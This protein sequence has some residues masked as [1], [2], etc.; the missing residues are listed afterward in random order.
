MH[1]ESEKS[2]LTS[3]WRISGLRGKGKVQ[4]ANGR[5]GEL[6]LV[7]HWQGDW[8]CPSGWVKWQ[9]HQVSLWEPKGGQS[10]C[11]NRDPR[12][13]KSQRFKGCGLGMSLGWLK[14]SRYH[15]ALGSR[16]TVLWPESATGVQGI[17]G[18]TPELPWH[19]LAVWL[20][21]YP[22]VCTEVERLAVKPAG[23]F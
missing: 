2:F 20:F 3:D 21:V 9:K 6:T 1:Y 22:R 15:N 10:R 13:P 12:R 17:L 4:M 16:H 11:V 7:G 8:S 23:T 5:R 18:S 14:E 19:S